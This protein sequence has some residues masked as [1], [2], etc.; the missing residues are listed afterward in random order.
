MSIIN[1]RGI[2]HDVTS[3]DYSVD[4]AQPVEHV[5]KIEIVCTEAD[6]ERWIPI[7]T[8]SARTGN[9]GDGLVCLLAVES[10]VRVFS[11]KQGDAALED[12]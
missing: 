8:A 3:L 11:G 5:V 7:L 2:G 4:L 10:V 6:A 1:V 9:R 12:V